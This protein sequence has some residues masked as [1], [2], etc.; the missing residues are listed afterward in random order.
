[1][2]QANPSRNESNSGP[3]QTRRASPRHETNVP[4]RIVIETAE[5]TGRAD[6]IS[7]GGVFLFSGDQLRVRV[8]VDEGNEART[9]SGR[10]VRVQQMNPNETGFAIEFD[11]A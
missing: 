8:E 5:F 9:F 3:A 1:M 10:L 11:R 7:A 6:N 4:L 2:T